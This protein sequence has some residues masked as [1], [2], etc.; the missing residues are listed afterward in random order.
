MYM[1]QKQNL[2]LIE[3]KDLQFTMNWGCTFD[4]AQMKLDMHVCMCMLVHSI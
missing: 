3:T 2:I 1:E 4:N